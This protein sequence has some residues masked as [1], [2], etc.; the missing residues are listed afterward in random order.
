MDDLRVDDDYLLHADLL[1]VI[2]LADRA[3]SAPGH[4]RERLLRLAPRAIIAADAPDRAAMFSVTEALEGLG[5]TYTQASIRMPY[6]AAW[7]A[8]RVSAEHSVL[9]G[10]DG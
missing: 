8:A 10:H 3:T 4:Q 6:R 2:P 9:R 7:A 1:R 5:D